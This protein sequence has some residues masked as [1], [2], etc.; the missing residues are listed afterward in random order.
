MKTSIIRFSLLVCIHVPL[1]ACEYQPTH[2]STPNQRAE[3]KFSATRPPSAND[4]TKIKVDDNI[5]VLSTTHVM[6]I[7]PELYQP[8]FRL[9]GTIIP[10]KQ[11][12]IHLPK[13]GKLSQLTVG[14]NTTIQKGET[15]AKFY[16]ETI[17]PTTN[18]SENSDDTTDKDG[19]KTNDKLDDSMD[20]TSVISREPFDVI[21]PMSG[22]VGS[23]FVQNKESTY[24]KNTPILTIFDDRLIKL[25]SPLPSEY[26]KFLAVGNGVSF[27]AEGGR[28]FVGQI[29][30]IVP[31]L[32]NVNLTKI[33]VAIKPDEVKKIGLKLGEH[34]SG[35]VNYG[36]IDVGILVPAFAI[37]DDADGMLVPMD[38]SDLSKPPHRPATPRP[39]WLWE[40]GQDERLSLLS[41]EVIEYRPQSDRYLIAGAK[42][43][44]LIV[45]ANLP[46]TTHGARVQL[47]R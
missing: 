43:D 31:V 5:V 10:H 27:D 46:K 45:M 8:A 29:T 4:N 39:A 13:E 9:E 35:Y 38:L 3:Q 41:I 20:I 21:A 23:I 40:I 7:K 25:I 16:Q 36:Q 6:S 15:V 18:L 30:E 34:V 17:V 44:G 47:R 24:T 19:N 22:R 12:T 28:T 33:H 42:L 26:A 2:S 11:A 32:D 37:F 1:I 14:I